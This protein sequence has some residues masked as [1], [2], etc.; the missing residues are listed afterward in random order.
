MVE[1]YKKWS[2]REALR[3]IR[4]LNHRNRKNSHKT[5]NTIVTIVNNS[6]KDLKMT[7]SEI[8]TCIQAVS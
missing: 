4:M 1:L 8:S 7:T 6:I 5:L 2:Y 3:K